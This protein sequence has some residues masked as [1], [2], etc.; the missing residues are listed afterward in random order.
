MTPR[1]PARTLAL[2]VSAATLATAWHAAPAAS[3]SAAA[4]DIL[5]P[6]GALPVAIA[7]SLRDPAAFFETTT[8]EAVVFDRRS[9]VVSVIDASRTKAR[10]LLSGAPEHG[11]L[12]SPGA[13]AI[14]P[15]DLIAVA[16][17]LRGY[18]RIQYFTLRGSRVGLLALPDPPRS[19]VTVNGFQVNGI[20]S[21]QFAKQSFFVNLPARGQLITELGVNGETLRQFGQPRRAGETPD[22]AVDAMLN[23]GLPLVDPTGG[24]YFVFQT[25]VPILRRY[26]AAGALVFERHIEGVE[27]DASIANLPTLWRRPGAEGQL[28]ITQPLVR[29]AA[30]DEQGRVWVALGVPYVYVYDQRGEKIRTIQL[31][32]TGPIVA[33]S[34]SFAT[35][36]RLLVAPGCYE[37]TIAHSG[38][39]VPGTR[40][41]E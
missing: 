19:H 4:V 12:V 9:G 27:L 36:H 37:F 16:D 5:R 33:E 34:L 6:T 32:G 1:A 11:G 20:G 23:I 3:A 8:G 30:V 2:A 22:P 13:V 35:G 41:P 40:L 25:G 28:P 39:G 38:S 26:D 15:E 10:V 31:N 7:T 29:S 14:G 17:S 21:L 18:D 24:F